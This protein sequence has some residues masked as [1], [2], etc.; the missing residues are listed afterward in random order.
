[1]D[2]GFRSHHGRPPS[3]PFELCEEARKHASFV[4]VSF[5]QPD[6]VRAPRRIARYPRDL[7][8]DIE[9]CERAAVDLVFAPPASEM[10]PPGE[11]TRVAS[12]GLTD[13]LCGPFRPQHFEGVATVVAKLFALA[14]PCVALF[15]RKDYQQLKVVERMTRDLL[16]S[17]EVRGIATVRDVDGLALSSRNAYRRAQ[18]ASEPGRFRA[19]WRFLGARS[20]R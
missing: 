16:F 15:G 8:G 4:A 2:G 19:G 10:Y 12:G 20:R 14:A 13:G 3:G 18:S 17:V 7:S 1:M 9:K 5:R 6:P 11:T